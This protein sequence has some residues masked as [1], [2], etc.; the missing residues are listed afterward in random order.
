MTRPRRRVSGCP[1]LRAGN[2]C[3]DRGMAGPVLIVDDDAPFLS[4]AA[5]ILEDLGIGEVVTAEDAATAIR[6]ANATRPAAALVDIGLPA[7]NGAD[8]APGLAGLPWRPRAGPAAGGRDAGG[9]L[10][11]DGPSPPP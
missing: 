3:D 9:A 10:G 1:Y 4:L 11:S 2:S 6:A 8:L 5:R 7:R